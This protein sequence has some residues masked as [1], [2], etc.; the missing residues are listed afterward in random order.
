MIEIELK[1]KIDAASAEKLTKWLKQ[2]A[3]AKGE[4]HQLE[5]Y[6]DNPDKTFFFQS[7]LGY[8]DAANYFRVRFSDKGDSVCLKIFEV[9]PKSTKSKNL[10]EIEFTVSDGEESLK[11]FKTLGFTDLTKV[12]KTRKSYAYKNFEIELDTV[13]GLGN[14]VEIE[15]KENDITVEEGKAKI[16]ELLKQI[17]IT[18]FQNCSRGYVS[19]LWN[20][21]YEFGEEEEIS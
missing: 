10:D 5:Y 13:E 9:D 1:I 7:E 15:I 6:L 21:D 2:N 14:F 8:K 11:L 19:M 18:R 4:K 16:R 17:G 20:P 12:E 3:E